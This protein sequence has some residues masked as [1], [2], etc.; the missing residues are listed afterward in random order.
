MV[1]FTF[2]VEPMGLKESSSALTDRSPCRL[3][4]AAVIAVAGRVGQ[5]LVHQLRRIGPA[6]TVQVVVQPLLDHVP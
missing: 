4:M 1:K 3:V 2:R 5:R 6:P